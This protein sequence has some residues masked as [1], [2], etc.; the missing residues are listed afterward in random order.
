MLFVDKLLNGVPLFCDPME[1]M[2]TVDN[3]AVFTDE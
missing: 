2:H 3:K 1:H